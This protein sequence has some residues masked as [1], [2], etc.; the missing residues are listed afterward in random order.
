MLYGPGQAFERLLEEQP[1]H[2]A[3]S[4][5]RASPC[6][7]SSSRPT[8]S[9]SSR[10]SVRIDSYPRFLSLEAFAVF[11][12]FAT[13]YGPEDA[14]YVRLHQDREGAPAAGS[15]RAMSRAS[16][17]RRDFGSLE[18]SGRWRDWR[19]GQSMMPLTLGTSV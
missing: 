13:S 7:S 19:A 18:P 9:G 3:E 8:R 1:E 11:G 5:P 15:W 14:V 4:S 17:S 16:P 6:C 10:I 12:C 2:P